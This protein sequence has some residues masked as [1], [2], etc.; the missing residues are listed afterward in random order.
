MNRINRKI[1]HSI[2]AF[3][4]LNSFECFIVILVLLQISA[5][6][7]NVWF[8]GLSKSRWLMI[9]GVA[10]LGVIFFSELLVFIKKW[11][12]GKFERFETRF[13]TFHT[14]TTLVRVVGFSLLFILIGLLTCHHFLNLQVNSIIT[15]LA[16]LFFLSE[17][18]T[19]QTII[20]LV[21]SHSLFSGQNLIESFKRQPL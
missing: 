14:N 1:F 15:R 4:S 3:L 19:L 11:I 6:P 13:R 12:K 17:L 10:F 2:I 21:F 8:M 18:L 5:D 9:M 20:F 16:P 7:K